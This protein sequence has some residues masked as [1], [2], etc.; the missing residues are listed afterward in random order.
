MNCIAST[1]REPKTLLEAAYALGV[2]RM[3]H[4]SSAGVL[5]GPPGSVIDETMAR[6]D[7]DANDYFRSKILSDR[8][9]LDFWGSSDQVSP[10]R[11][12]TTTWPFD[13]VATPAASPM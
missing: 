3:V 2:R 10:V 13:V 1:S 5:D 11:V 6:A 8:A 9:I 4:T 7:A 12:Y